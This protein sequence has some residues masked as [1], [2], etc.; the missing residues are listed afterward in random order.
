[1]KSTLNSRRPILV[2]AVVMMAV[3]IMVVGC[4]HDPAVSLAAK[5]N[6]LSYTQVNLVS[7][8]DTF[9]PTPITIDP[10]MLNAWGLAMDP[11]GD[12]GIAANHSGMGLFYD[13]EG[14]AALPAI[15]IPAFDGTFPGAPSGQ[16]YNS[17]NGF[18]IPST[19]EK[20]KFIFSTED[21][22]ICAWASGPN[23]IMVVPQIDDNAVYKGLAMAMHGGRPYLYAT[24]FRDHRID[25]F[26]G[27]FNRVM[28]YK[29]ADPTIP[30]NY[31]PF[32]ITNIDGKLWVA[33]AVPKSPDF[34]DDSAGLGNGFVNIFNPNG[35]RVRRFYSHGVLNSPWGITMA[36]EGFGAFR[37]TILIGDFGD[38]M[39]NAFDNSGKFM[40]SL[41]MPGGDP[42]V[43]DGLWAISAMP[44]HG[45]NRIFF[46]AGPN[47]E[48]DGLFGYL[49]AQ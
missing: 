43:I 18:V 32:S 14:I 5:S 26:D 46:T 36:P 11:E 45:Q 30:E 42:V 17:S 1:M 4:Q 9:T 10:S 12:F 19:G 16:V 39:I 20:A 47:E 22:I 6:T 23:A 35:M 34:V 25:V 21:G 3:G 38:G 27:S 15:Q 40:G 41:M 24:N 13:D 48:E 37:K 2:L 44:G 31:S 28:D 29:F 33:Y 8:L 49:Q 7:D